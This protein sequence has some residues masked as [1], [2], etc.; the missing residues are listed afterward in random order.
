MKLWGLENPAPGVRRRSAAPR[1][2]RWPPWWGKCCRGRRERPRPAARCRGP[3]PAAQIR[4]PG[5][6][7]K[8]LK[9][10]HP[11]VTDDGGEPEHHLHERQQTRTRL[12][13][14]GLQQCIH[15]HAVSTARVQNA[16][17]SIFGVLWKYAVA[18]QLRVRAEGQ[19][20]Q[21]KTRVSF[22]RKDS[23]WTTTNYQSESCQSPSGEK[24]VLMIKKELLGAGTGADL[25][26]EGDWLLAHGVRVTNVGLDDLCEGLLHSLTNRNWTLETN[27]TKGWRLSSQIETKKFELLHAWTI[28]KHMFRAKHCRS[29]QNATK[30]CGNFHTIWFPVLT[31]RLCRL[32]E[33]DY[34][35]LWS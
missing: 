3:R 32:E 6:R 24:G 28:Q 10:I 13:R 7:C 2:R 29:G 14:W 21:T 8:H 16:A 15:T 5:W 22:R 31:T 25:S 1:C 35:Q 9:E 12:G 33:A 30:I 23:T 26:E 17:C 4:C 34:H 19:D 11:E 27:W 18:Q 20:L